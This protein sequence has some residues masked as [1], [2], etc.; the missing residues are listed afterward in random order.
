ME[1]FYDRDEHFPYLDEILYD[2]DFFA[3]GAKSPSAQKVAVKRT[4]GGDG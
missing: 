2:F 3:Q 4:I 1:T